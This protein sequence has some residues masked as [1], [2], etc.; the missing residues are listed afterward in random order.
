MIMHIHYSVATGNIVAWGDGEGCEPYLPGHAVIHIA[1][2]EIDPK[3]HKVDHASR[4]VILKTRDDAIASLRVEV[5]QAIERELGFTDHFVDPPSD[6]P[7]KGAF[8]FDWKPYRQT[9]RDL[10]KLPGPADMVRAWPMRPNDVDAI[11]HLRARI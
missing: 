1:K 8:A 9:L 10:S 11:P 3:R 5:E 6:R 2:R 4:R 7:R